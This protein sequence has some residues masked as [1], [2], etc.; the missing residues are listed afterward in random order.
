MILD[1]CVWLSKE[2]SS[3]IFFCLSCLLQLGIQQDCVHALAVS[4]LKVSQ[5]FE[6]VFSVSGKSPICLSRLDYIHLKFPKHRPC[7]CNPG[8]VVA[9]LQERRKG[10]ETMK[11]Y[12]LYHLPLIH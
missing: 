10:E 1:A 8:T 7:L 2:Y 3:Y 11:Y 4:L 12:V 9:N 6:N 5:P